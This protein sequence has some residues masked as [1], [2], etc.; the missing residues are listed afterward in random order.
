MGFRRAVRNIGTEAISDAELALLR[1]QAEFEARKGELFPEYFSG[2]R[3]RLLINGKTIG[4]ALEVNWAVSS[5][6]TEVRTVDAT[7][8]WEIVPGQLQ[9]KASLKRIVD[10]RRNLASDGLF[11]TLQAHLHQPYSSIEVRDKLGTLVFLARG[12]FTDIQGTVSNGQLGIESASFTGYYYRENVR[13]EFDAQ[14]DGSPTDIF[15]S[16]F[17]NL[18]NIAKGGVGS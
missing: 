10:P 11:S 4:A 15:Q 14:S 17:K 1:Q 8:P 18:I 9:I 13:Q 3:A 16:R 7:V 2:A 12:M 5:Q 6:V